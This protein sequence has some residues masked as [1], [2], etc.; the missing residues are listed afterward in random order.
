M[1]NL[2]KFKLLLYGVIFGPVIYISCSLTAGKYASDG[3]IEWTE[4][5]SSRGRIEFDSISPVV[6]HYRESKI[7]TGRYLNSRGEPASTSIILSLI[8]EVYDSYLE[9]VTVEADLAGVFEAKLIG[10]TATSNF[11][12]RAKASDGAYG[13]IEINVGAEQTTSIKINPVYDGRRRIDTYM[14]EIYTD[15]DCP[16]LA[17]TLLTTYEA[18]VREVPIQLLDIPTGIEVTIQLNGLVCLGE[19]IECE[20]WVGGCN[21]SVAINVNDTSPKTIDVEISDDLRY[22]S[23]DSFVV[24]TTIDGR[25]LLEEPIEKLFQPLQP[26][27]ARSSDVASFILN[28][29][30]NISA[31]AL[32]EE[33]SNVFFIQRQERDVDSRIEQ[34][35]ESRGNLSMEITQLKQLTLEAVADIEL[36]GTLEKDLWPQDP[37]TVINALYTLNSITVGDYDLTTLIT[38]PDN[39]FTATPRIYYHYDRASIGSHSLPVA[40]GSFLLRLLEEVLAASEYH[41]PMEEGDILY[42]YLLDRIPCHEISYTLS[43]TIDLPSIDDDT[44]W[45]LEQCRSILTAIVNEVDTNASEID[46][47]HPSISLEG[48]ADFLLPDGSPRPDRTAAGFWEEAMWGESNHFPSPPYFNIIPVTE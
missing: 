8:G 36:T 1:Y 41:I 23:S 28:Q 22:F 46:F 42:S 10:G 17:D 25:E 12:L 24:I 11:I 14:V 15:T 5:Q 47:T 18:E 37:S 4:E 16:P 33:D 40:G 31:G 27:S 43:N 13:Q 34:I 6:L 21:N 44:S 29:I 19:E 39:F 38:S 3:S 9:Q 48:T 35:I 45:Y 7:I 2:K 32:G 30:Q 26:L 20:R